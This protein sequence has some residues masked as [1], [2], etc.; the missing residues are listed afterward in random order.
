MI[1][2]SDV[3]VVTSGIRK[4]SISDIGEKVLESAEGGLPKTNENEKVSLNSAA[5]NPSKG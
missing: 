3:T 4:T 1:T 5:Q 2:G